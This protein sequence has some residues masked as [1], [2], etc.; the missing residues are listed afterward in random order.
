MSNNCN[1]TSNNKYFDC[2]ARMDDGRLFTDYRQSS[3]VDDLIRFSNNVSSSYDYRQFLIHN[4]NNIMNI[5]SQYI[6]DKAE[7]SNCTANEVPFA[8]NCYVN[9][10]FTKCVP[11]NV[12]GVG[13]NNIVEVPNN[14]KESYSNKL[15]LAQKISEE[16]NSNYVDV[17]EESLY[18]Q[19]KQRTNKYLNDR[20]FS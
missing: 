20:I 4:G 10:Q 12:N 15:N 2:P 19:Q 17:T 3:T 5:N 1:K 18:N 16:T 8:T 7:C 9:N 13:I 14:S 11:T 6:K